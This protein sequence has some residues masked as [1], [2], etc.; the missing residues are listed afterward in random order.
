METNAGSTER[1]IDFKVKVRGRMPNLRGASPVGRGEGGRRARQRYRTPGESARERGGAFGAERGDEES[2]RVGWAAV[3]REGW[4]RRPGQF[5]A[6][7]AGSGRSGPVWTSL[8]GSGPVWDVWAGLGRSGPVLDRQGG[9][10]VWTVRTRAGLDRVGAGSGLGAWAGR[11]GLV[12]G[13]LTGSGAVRAGS[14]DSDRQE[15]GGGP[16]PAELT[17]RESFTSSSPV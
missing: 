16:I 8:D 17:Q 10:T 15:G 4:R 11:V 13:D 9:S 12:W 1:N 7:W 6:I 14:A 5:G 3:S 2:W